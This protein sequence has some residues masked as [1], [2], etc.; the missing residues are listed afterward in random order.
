MPQT[1]IRAPRVPAE[2]RE[3][4]G[5]PATVSWT[6]SWSPVPGSRCQTSPEAAQ[7]S[8]KGRGEPHDV[9]SKEMPPAS[10]MPRLVLPTYQP[11]RQVSKGTMR[12]QLQQFAFP[13][14]FAVGGHVDGKEEWP[15]S[16]TWTPETAGILKGSSCWPLF[17]KKKCGFLWPGNLVR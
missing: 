4:G 7:A 6:S 16:V 17:R 12:R 2:L 9:G 1:C 3:G 5:G 8:F 13:H 11:P 15:V 10:I 14:G